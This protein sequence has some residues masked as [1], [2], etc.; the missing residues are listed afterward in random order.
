MRRILRVWTTMNRD[1]G[2]YQLSPIWTQVIFTPK[3][4]GE[5]ASTEWLG[6]FIAII[7]TFRCWSL[8]KASDTFDDFQVLTKMVDS[9]RNCQHH[10][11][12]KTL[13]MFWERLKRYFD[14]YSNKQKKNKPVLIK[15]ILSGLHG[16][17]T[18]QERRNKQLMWYLPIL[19]SQCF[20]MFVDFR[21]NFFF[22]HT[23]LY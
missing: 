13:A 6:A 1:E 17:R 12:F 5:G 23:N 8:F 16:S 2:A 9:H 10:Q 4:G 7:S 20:Y 21:N 14:I 18:T 15:Y 19:M 22:S 11:D 3:P